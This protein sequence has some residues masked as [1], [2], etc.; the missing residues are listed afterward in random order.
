LAWVAVAKN[1]YFLR[2]EKLFFQ[3]GVLLTSGMTRSSSFSI[4]EPNDQTSPALP[5]KMQALNIV[6]SH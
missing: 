4:H 3:H 5:K 2:P 6:F 1:N